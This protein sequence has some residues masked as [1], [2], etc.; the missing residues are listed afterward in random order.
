MLTLI[1]ASREIS[2]TY[3]RVA[4]NLKREGIYRTVRHLIL[5]TAISLSLVLPCLAQTAKRPAEYI[6]GKGDLLSI[7]FWQRPELNS[8]TRVDAAGAIELPLI[9]SIPAAGSTLSQLRDEVL[10]RVTLVDIRIT[11]VSIV[12]REYA[13]NVVYV[14][15]SVLSPGKLM[16]ETIPNLW[17]IILE[18][19]GPQP[20]AKLNE[21]AITRG[22]GAEA[23]KTIQVNLESALNRGDISALPAVY[24]GDNVNVPGVMAPTGAATLPSSVSDDRKVVHVFG[25]VVTP[26]IFDYKPEM[27]L[28]D[29]IVLAG[30]PNPTANLKKVQLFFRGQRQA[31]VAIIDVER[32]MHRSTPL[33]PLLHP[34]DAIYV[35]PKRQLSPFLSESI[36]IIFTSSVSL[37]LVLLLQQ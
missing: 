33:P 10:N 1:K 6:L 14:T 5:A 21:V 30:G 36:R 24:P 35:P 22:R 26:G 16:F 4:V 19:G 20:T 15:G 9:G 23:G 37:L 25:Q 12:V 18:A 7:S 31:E 32:Y 8:D 28:F 27:S 2:V 34:G 29:A 11:Q 13:S 17:Q 3:H